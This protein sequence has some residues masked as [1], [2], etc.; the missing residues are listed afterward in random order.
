MYILL[1]TVDQFYCTD[2]MVNLTLRLATTER[3]ANTKQLKCM[4]DDLK[5]M[6]KSIGG[7]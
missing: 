4:Y 6:K 1:I 3:L 5:A 2:D 7:S